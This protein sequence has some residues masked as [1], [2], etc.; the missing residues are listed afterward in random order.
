MM[1]VIWTVEAEQDR[2]DVWEYIAS[3]NPIAAAQIDELFSRVADRLAE[4][5]EMGKPGKVSGTREYIP[6][7]SYRLIYEI[8]RETVWILALIHTA[9]RWPLVR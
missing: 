2:Y 9:R 8:E 7:E 3:D 5:P 4:H 1:K 6:H